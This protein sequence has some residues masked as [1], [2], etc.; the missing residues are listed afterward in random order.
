MT[1][2]GVHFDWTV[3]LTHVATLLSLIV[4]G[5]Y[6]YTDL[7]SDVRDHKTAADAKFAEYDRNWGLQRGIDVDQ[8]A[9]LERAVGELHQAMREL[10]QDVRQ[11]IKELRGDL[12]RGMPRAP[13][14]LP[15]TPS[16]R[17][18]RERGG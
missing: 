5:L 6:A 7:K 18:L 9:R 17:P 15:P 3:N 8:N 1:K 2:F 13:I 10:R 12:S 14:Y 11:D 4:A 16:E